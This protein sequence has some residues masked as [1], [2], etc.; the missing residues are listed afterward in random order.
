MKSLSMCACVCVSSCSDSDSRCQTIYFVKSAAGGISYSIVFQFLITIF[1]FVFST[2]LSN[3][4]ANEIG[5]FS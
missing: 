3:I 1:F 2:R 4:S 5:I